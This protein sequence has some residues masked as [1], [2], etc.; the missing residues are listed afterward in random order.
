MNWGLPEVQAGFRKGTG[1]RYQVA[2][3]SYIKKSKTISE[4]KK[5][6][7]SA[8]LTMLEPLTLWITTD[9]GNFFKW[10]E[11]HIT[12]L[13][14][15]E[16][17]MQVKKQQLIR[18]DCILSSCLFNL[19]A[20]YITKNTRLDETQAEIRFP[21]EIS[22]TSD[23]QMTSPYGRKWR[24][25]KKPLYESERGEWKSWLETTFKKWRSW[26]PFPSLYG[27]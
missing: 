5:K 7:T 15:W 16:I 26:H 17:C 21:G 22:I 11:Y 24:G 23:M 18:Q 6:S 1:T 9:C 10:W 25:T 2:N 13:A 3:I 27:K 8:A 4:K 12:L 19:Y 14:S 20:E